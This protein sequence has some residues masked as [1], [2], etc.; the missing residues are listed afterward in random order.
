MIRTLARHSRAL[1]T[2]REGSWPFRNSSAGFGFCIPK[3]VAN[4]EKSVKKSDLCGHASFILVDMPVSSFWTSFAHLVCRV[5]MASILSGFPRHHH[6]LL[7]PPHL[8]A[9]TCTIYRNTARAGTHM[10]HGVGGRIPNTRDMLLIPGEI[11]R[12]SVNLS[13]CGA[14]L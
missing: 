6:P 4:E 14:H 10:S 12:E 11:A 9:L 7:F 3:I 5:H 1:A 2:F 13:P 8:C